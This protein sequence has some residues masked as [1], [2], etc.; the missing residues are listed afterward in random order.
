DG[1]DCRGPLQLTVAR[2]AE[3][4]LEGLVGLVEEVVDHGDGEGAAGF[5]GGY[6]E[7]TRGSDVVEAGHRV[8]VGGGP[9]HQEIDGCRVGERD[10]KGDRSSV[11]ENARIGDGNP[12]RV[13]DRGDGRIV[14]AGQAGVVGELDR[15][16]IGF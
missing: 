5:T 6:L 3:R 9:R 15:E 8:D 2:R 11:L 7:L 14:G 10:Y 4:E 13:S 1:A 16:T 12:R